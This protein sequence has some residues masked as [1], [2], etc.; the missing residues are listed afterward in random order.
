METQLLKRLIVLLFTFIMV[1][2]LHVLGADQPAMAE[3]NDS[4]IV[5][6]HLVRYSSSTET[7]Y[8]LIH[9]SF[10]CGELFGASGLTISNAFG[11]AFAAGD[12]QYGK[13]DF[14]DDTCV[15]ERKAFLFDTDELK[16]MFESDGDLVITS[17]G[18]GKAV[19]YQIPK[20]IRERMLKIFEDIP[21]DIESTL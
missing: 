2:G 8:Y 6:Y 3:T 5:Q 4:I 18:R 7:M 14:Y 13:F 9:N 16:A 20:P 17:Y 10:S 1:N 19:H 12:M 21:L 15:V 11:F